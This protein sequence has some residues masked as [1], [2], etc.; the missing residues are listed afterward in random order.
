MTKPVQGPIRHPTKPKLKAPPHACDCHCHV[1]GPTDRFPYV[2]ERNYTPPQSTLQ[3]YLKLLD[4]L[5][6]ERTVLVQP[7][8]YGTDNR[9]HE[10][11]IVCMGDRARGVA[12]VDAD[13]DDKELTRLDKVGFR[14]VRFNL[15]HTGGST[16]LDH[17]EKL[18]RKVARLG[19]H[20]QLYMRGRILPEI[21]LR[22]SLLPTEIV[23]DH[24]GHFEAGQDTT[25]PG[26]AALLRLLESGRCWV[27]LC[28]YRFDP[29]GFPYG[30]AMPFARALNHAAPERLVWGTDW[31]HPDV[32]GT[33]EG[34]NGPMP[35]DGALL[36]ALGE[37][38]PDRATI[39]R[40]LV[41]N[42]ARLYGFVPLVRS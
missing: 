33:R 30:N 39:E 1:F 12:V 37:W 9:A 32:P 13:I 18:A 19:W 38:F 40:I 7:S 4:H 29:S 26:F 6:I 42:P 3:D 17:M 34:E 15:I 24:L 28:P 20:V 22:L 2:S 31:P 36:D 25:Q 14:G 41:A 10:D 35:D 23:I 11:A 16:S 27:K 21:E 8:I 5:G